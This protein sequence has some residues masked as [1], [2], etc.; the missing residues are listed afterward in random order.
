MLLTFVLDH[1]RGPILGFFGPR[2]IDVVAL[3]VDL[4]PMLP[5]GSTY[6]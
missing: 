4:L 3:D 1:V 2:Y 5:P 6:S